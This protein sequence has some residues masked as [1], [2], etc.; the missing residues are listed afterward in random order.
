MLAPLPGFDQEAVVELLAVEYGSSSEGLLFA[1]LGEDSWCYRAGSFWVSVR[2]D[3]RG[4]DPATYAAAT[5]LH[6]R[7]DA[8]V[9]APLRGASGAVVHTIDGLPVVVFPYVESSPLDRA[10]ASSDE[11]RQVLAMLGKLHESGVEEGLATESFDLSFTVELELVERIAEGEQPAGGVYG[12]PL[13]RLLRAHHE[14]VLEW[15]AEYDELARRCRGRGFA[16]RLTHGEPLASNVLRTAQG[17]MLADW[18]ELMIGPAERDWSHVERTLGAK[19]PC[20][21]DLRRLYDLRW[22]LSEVGEYTTALDRSHTGGADDDAM[23]ERLTRY[24]PTAAVVAEGPV[25][26]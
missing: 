7:G 13:G 2:R 6:E 8:F 3:L 5:E 19:L 1:P 20:D 21:P 18:G 26:R 4:H 9:L 16:P 14:R 25:A 10:D 12:A 22:L 15:W 17:L 23:W 24:L 11:R